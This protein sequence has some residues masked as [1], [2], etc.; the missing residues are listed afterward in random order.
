MSICTPARRTAMTVSRRSAVGSSENATTTRSTSCSRTI[1][2]RRS[3]G[4]STGTSSEVGA[5][6]PRRGVDEADQPDA[7]LAVLHQLARDELADVAGADDHRVLDVRRA[8]MEH[9]PGDRA[10][11][12][13]EGDRERPERDELDQARVGEMGERRSDEQEPGA[14]GDHH[15]HRGQVVDRRVVGA[16]VVAVVQAEELGRDQPGRQRHQERGH[17]ERQ[18]EPVALPAGCAV[19]GPRRRPSRARARRRSAQ[20]SARVSWERPRRT[21]GALTTSGGAS[22]ERPSTLGLRCVIVWWCGS[23]PSFHQTLRAGACHLQTRPDVPPTGR[24][25]AL[26]PVR[27]RDRFADRRCPGTLA[28]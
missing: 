27:R 7:V 28:S 3:G 1:S 15:E 24:H 9:G 10:A 18:R 16:L 4:P 22:R 19:A 21:A 6:P 14:D 2:S 20:T 17:L 5:H 8:A 13:D 23:S 12:G 26:R 25:L 11:D